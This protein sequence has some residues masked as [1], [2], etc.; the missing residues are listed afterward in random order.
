MEPYVSCFK[1]QVFLIFLFDTSLEKG[2]ATPSITQK[3]TPIQM[4][5][6]NLNI[7]YLNRTYFFIN[8]NIISEN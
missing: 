6:P 3:D 2:N 4:I 5:Y 7:Y 8:T 1:I